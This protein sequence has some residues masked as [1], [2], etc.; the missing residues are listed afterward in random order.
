MRA[1]LQVSRVL[2]AIPERVWDVISAGDRVERWF[3]WVAGTD[4]RDG[5]EG[6]LRVIRMNDGTAFDEYV[7]V[8]DAASRTYQYYAPEPPLPIRHVIG[9]KRLR[10]DVLGRAILEWS[11]SFDVMDGASDDIVQQMR[12]LY[13]EALKKID[14]AADRTRR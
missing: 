2:E 11:V 12:E 9:T 8:N 6:G 10:S 3:E 13:L 1:N 5:A 14:V 7:T 4:L